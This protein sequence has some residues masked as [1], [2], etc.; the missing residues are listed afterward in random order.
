MDFSDSCEN[1]TG[2]IK[3]ARR[4]PFL[5]RGTPSPTPEQNEAHVCV[6]GARRQF[7]RLSW[8]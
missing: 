6:E 3:E 4:F 1:R 5:R 7:Q 2:W 8:R